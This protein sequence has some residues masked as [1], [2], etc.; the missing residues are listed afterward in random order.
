MNAQPQLLSFA[1]SLVILVLIMLLLRRRKLREKYAVLWILVGLGGVSISIWPAQL[2]Y[3][4]RNLGFHLTSNFLFFV[5]AIVLLL[6]SIQF[7][8]ELSRLEARTERLAE[9]VALL[10]RDDGAAP[11][12]ST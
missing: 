1:L 6:I 7:S 11:P 2:V 3:F 12:P 5:D 9:E 8:V 4:S 10:K